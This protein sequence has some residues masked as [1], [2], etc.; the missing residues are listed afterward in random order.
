[1]V[2]IGSVAVVAPTVM[3]LRTLRSLPRI[4]ALGAVMLA[5]G[6][7]LILIGGGQDCGVG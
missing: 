7:W 1:M 6:A 3:A 5:A 4:A 2:S